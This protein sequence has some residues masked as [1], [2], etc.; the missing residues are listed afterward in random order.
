MSEAWP[1][2][3]PPPCPACRQEIGEGERATCAACGLV[4]HRSC[5]ERERRCLRTTCANHRPSHLRWSK[6]ARDAG[7]W[8]HLP[9]PP[10]P[11]LLSAVVAI[12]VFPVAALVALPCIP[13]YVGMA[14]AKLLPDLPAWLVVAATSALIVVPSL[15]FCLALWHQYAQYRP[16][17]LDERG[18]LLGYTEAFSGFRVRWD[19]IRGYKLRPR[20]IELVLARRPWTRWTLA[21][22]VLCDERVAHDVTVILEKHGIVNAEG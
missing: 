7:P 2:G 1:A 10:P 13:L 6:E 12:L 19:Q 17:L 5:A 11:R 14:L 8:L 15:A 4:H 22:M 18:V 16:A 20:G 21:P 3:S 9:S